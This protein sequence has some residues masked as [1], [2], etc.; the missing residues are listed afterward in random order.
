[1]SL[2]KNQ[3]GLAACTAVATLLLFGAVACIKQTDQTVLGYAPVYGNLADL[4]TIS[5][6]GPQAIVH[7]GKIYAYQG[8]TFQI[9]N[10]EGIHVIQSSDPAHPAKIGFI[11]VKGCSEISIRNNILYTDNHRDLVGIQI[12]NPNQISVVSRL[13]EVFPGVNQEYPPVSGTYFECADAKKG[14]VIA[15]TEKLLTNPKCKR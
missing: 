12:S 13:S 6:D 1:M 2:I 15:W 9:E 10:G 4:K 11:R 8:Y 7:A 5:A 14:T 3:R